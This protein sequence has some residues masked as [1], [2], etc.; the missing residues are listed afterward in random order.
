ME[1]ERSDLLHST[2][3]DGACFLDRRQHVK[4]R[5]RQSVAQRPLAAL[6]KALRG[7]L[8]ALSEPGWQHATTGLA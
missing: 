4:V 1:S 8:G 7:T 3:G 5:R 6:R 2:G